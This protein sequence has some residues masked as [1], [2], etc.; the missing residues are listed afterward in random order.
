MNFNIK[1]NMSMGQLAQLYTG[2][3][4]VTPDQ[5]NSNMFLN[6]SEGYG[7]VQ[8]QA[9]NLGIN[10]PANYFNQQ[11]T[12]QQLA[13]TPSGAQMMAA[14]DAGQ[15]SPQSL[16]GQLAA[17]D[18]MWDR[19]S[20]QKVAE[21]QHLASLQNQTTERAFP[22][23]TPG[24]TPALSP[25]MQQDMQQQGY[26]DPNAYVLAQ[27]LGGNRSAV[28]LPNNLNG[29]SSI[30]PEALLNDPTFQP[31]LK[32]QPQKAGQIFQSL[33]GQPL[34]SQNKDNPG[35]MEQSL[36][37]KV[38]QRKF[39]QDS[40]QKALL[41]GEAKVQPDGSTLWQ[42]SIPD[43]MGTGKMILSSNYGQGNAY[44]KTLEKHI[45]NVSPDLAAFKA[46][47]AKRAANFATM[48]NANPQSSPNAAPQSMQTSSIWGNG[49]MGT[50]NNAV[51]GMISDVG[52]IATGQ[53][54]AFAGGDQSQGFD[55]PTGS[56]ARHAAPILRNNPQF[57][58]LLRTNPE[59]A[60]RMIL[61]IQG[62]Q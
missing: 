54:Q 10:D 6:S 53:A 29:N 56:A 44:Q 55:A 4:N 9:Q 1:Q 36:Q 35:Y 26:S 41:S 5:V 8:K 20:N 40:L 21:T 11:Q 7:Y 31:W 25:A 46:L 3:P 27:R 42:Q 22:L 47:A 32:S 48:Q 23:P 49:I 34:F 28:N 38:Q 52:N 2:N 59:A 61:S 62:A 33:T 43:P 24:V 50:A 58:Q 37:A 19:I 39:E 13:N 18:A 45:Q 16:P 17:R 15:Y 57:Q 51:Q 60:R 14:R 30:D 12:Q